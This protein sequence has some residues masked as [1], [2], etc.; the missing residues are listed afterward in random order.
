MDKTDM[1]VSL[2]EE[3]E[4]EVFQTQGRL[5]EGFLCCSSVFHL[6]PLAAS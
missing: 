6:D 5:R 1:C 4:E 2:T 3:E